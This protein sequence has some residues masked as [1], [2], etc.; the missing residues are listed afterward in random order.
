ME[1][2]GREDTAI[3]IFR[4]RNPSKVFPTLIPHVQR[5]DV[6]TLV[7]DEPKISRRYHHSNGLAA[8]LTFPEVPSFK[9]E[10]THLPYPSYLTIYAQL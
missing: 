6:N 10:A 7:D 9:P 1:E 8:V 3:E 2:L 4:F 5:Q